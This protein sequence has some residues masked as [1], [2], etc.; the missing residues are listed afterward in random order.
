MI[1]DFERPSTVRRSAWAQVHSSCARRTITAL[2]SAR[3]AC[4]SPPREAAERGLRTLHGIVEP[5][6]AGTHRRAH[7]DPLGA[8][9][10]FESFSQ[11]G[12]RRC[13]RRL[14]RTGS[15]QVPPRSCRYPPLRPTIAHRGR[16][17]TS[18]V[19]GNH[20][21]CFEL[22]CRENPACNVDR[23]CMVRAPVGIDAADD[24]SAASCHARPAFL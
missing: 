4:R 6:L 17:A 18:E 9:K 7:F 5:G 24:D 22:R 12:R 15:G 23:R 13:D 8:R 3:S 2:Y 11:R 19:R 1:S 21:C 20:G 10:D 16:A 14:V